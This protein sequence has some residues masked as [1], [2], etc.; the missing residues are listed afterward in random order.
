MAVAHTCGCVGVSKMI[1]AFPAHSGQA[2]SNC[3]IATSS[4]TTTSRLRGCAMSNKVR[5][6]AKVPMDE[7]SELRVVVDHRHSG[8][9]PLIHLREYTETAGQWFPTSNGIALE[10]KVIGDLVQALYSVANDERS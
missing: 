5:L 3:S 10:A 1:Q 6:M 4:I 8:T 9:I 2:E 7:G